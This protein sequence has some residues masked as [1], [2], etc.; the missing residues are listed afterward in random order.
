MACEP[1]HTG[2]PESPTGQA[3]TSG[4]GHGTARTFL[5]PHAP[6]PV[7]G[8]QASCLLLPGLESRFRSKSGYLRYSC[9]SRIR[10]Y[11]REVGRAAAGTRA[12]S[13]SRLGLGTG[14]P[15]RS[16]CCRLSFRRFSG[17]VACALQPHRTGCW[18]TAHCHPLVWPV[19]TASSFCPVLLRVQFPHNCRVGAELTVPM[20]PVGWFTRD[21]TCPE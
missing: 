15:P 4:G 9:E 14:A 13:G 8:L 21:A 17:T 6:A 18:G 19:P 3:R 2:G 20:S 7:A 11:L 10:S 1:L 5:S 16:A 12:G